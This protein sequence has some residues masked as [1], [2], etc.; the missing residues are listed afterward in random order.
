MRWYK[1]ENKVWKKHDLGLKCEQWGSGMGDI[2][3]DG[4]A[5]IICPDAWLEAPVNRATGTWI[6]HIINSNIC[7]IVEEPEPKFTNSAGFISG[8]ATQIYTYDVNKDGLND[9]LLSSGHSNGIFWYQ[10]AKSAA[11]AITFLERMID[12]SWYQSHNLE[13]KDVNGDGFPDLV[14]GKRWAG[15]GPNENAANSIFWYQLTPGA[16]NPWKRHTIS[17][18]EKSGMGCK[19]DVRDFDGDGDMDVLATSLDAQGTVLYIN[20][21]KPVP[22]LVKQNGNQKSPRFSAYGNWL[23]TSHLGYLVA[24]K[25]TMRLRS[26]S[27]RIMPMQEV[28]HA[29]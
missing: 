25:G 9:I 17:Y 21:M 15:W 2:N 5:D 3:G 10:Q 6:K 11:G 18:N 27:G 14:S 22:I 23:R 24:E 29:K 13:F 12:R 1:V 20:D 26:P 4:R 16:A 28:E 8:H 19:G 7:N